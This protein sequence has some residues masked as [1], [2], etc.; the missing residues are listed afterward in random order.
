MI[1]RCLVLSSALLLL[2]AILAGCYGGRSVGHQEKTGS[3]R[4]AI[5][6]PDVRQIKSVMQDESSIR[7][8]STGGELPTQVEVK[9]TNGTTVLSQTVMLQNGAAEVTFSD[10]VVGPW[11]IIVLLKDAENNLA[12]EGSCRVAITADQMAQASVLL[13]PALGTLELTVDLTGIPDHE[14]VAK[15]RLYKD[16]NNLKSQTNI[17]REPGANIIFALVSNLR[18][19][20]YDMMIKLYDDNGDL[21]YES[22]W[23]SMEILPGRVTKADWDFSSGGVSIVVDCN[24][25]PSPPTNLTVAL[26]ENEVVLTWNE[27]IDSDLVGYKVYRRQ[28]PFDG[29]KVAAEVS[30]SPGQEQSFMDV[31]T[32]SGNTYSYFVTAIDTADNESSRSNEVTINAP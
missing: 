30:H 4:V 14:R 6:S 26:S 23:A 5:S 22:L 7:P 19:K 11:T 16:S 9:L 17:E 27:S 10:V 1:K 3:V 28:V 25:P 15:L 8:N 13:Q 24:D 21:V 29:F 20:T 32:K 2:C 12:Y 31:G 18:P